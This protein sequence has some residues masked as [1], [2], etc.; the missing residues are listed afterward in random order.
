MSEIV[1]I[2]AASQNGRNGHKHPQSFSQSVNRPICTSLDSGNCTK[3][4]EGYPAMCTVGSQASCSSCGISKKRSTRSPSTNPSCAAVSPCRGSRLASKDAGSTSGNAK[5]NTLHDCLQVQSNITPVAMRKRRLQ[6]LCHGVL[7]GNSQQARCGDALTERSING[8]SQTCVETA[9]LAQSCSIK[10]RVK[11]LSQERGMTRPK[12]PDT[13]ASTL[14]GEN[15][16]SHSFRMECHQNSGR[17]SRPNGA[18][19]LLMRAH[20]QSQASFPEAV[21][22]RFN[23]ARGSLRPHRLQSETQR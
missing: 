17:P 5:E 12:A 11:L 18:R 4:E 8:F 1:R 9:M 15:G 21:P 23:F 6:P 7:P 20:F 3:R 22:G 19:C 14:K 13:L 2:C 10:R 16:R